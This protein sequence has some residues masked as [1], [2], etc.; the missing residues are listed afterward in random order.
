MRVEDVGSYYVDEEGDLW[1]MI[2]YC[3]YPTATM[4]RVDV[5]NGQMEF[6][7]EQRGGAVGSPILSGF[8][9]FV[10]DGKTT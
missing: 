7:K 1:L 10:P 9:K 5:K 3:E 6:A 4:E 2:G 8:R